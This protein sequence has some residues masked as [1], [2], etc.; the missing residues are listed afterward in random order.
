M[1][2]LPEM[3]TMAEIRRRY[4]A[5]MKKWHPDTA[6]EGREACEAM[7]RRI[8][9]A[10]QTIQAY[11]ADYRYRFT[12]EEVERYV[13]AEEWWMRRFGEH[14]PGDG[15]KENEEKEPEKGA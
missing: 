11:C 1:L 6:S 7:S 13:S 14:P 5:L 4:R 12:R 9:A 8:Q 2:G 10:Y 15:S 3:A